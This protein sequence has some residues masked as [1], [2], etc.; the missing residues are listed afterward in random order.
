M[1]N[2]RDGGQISGCQDLKLVEVGMTTEGGAQGRSYDDS[3]LS[4]FSPEQK[5]SHIYY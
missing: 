3:S 2:Y 5:V 4:F 1:T